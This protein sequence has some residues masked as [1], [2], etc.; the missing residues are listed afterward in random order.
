MSV[1]LQADP[2]T[3][4]S[5]T[6]W[7]K[8]RKRHDREAEH[9]DQ[10]WYSI[11]RD[12]YQNDYEPYPADL[13]AEADTRNDAV[14]LIAARFGVIVWPDDVVDWWPDKSARWQRED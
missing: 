2:S 11:E 7:W 9:C 8:P 12:N 13:L 14:V 6:I 1:A 4:Q 5:V 10:W 3:V